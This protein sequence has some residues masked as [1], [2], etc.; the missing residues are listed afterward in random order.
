[1]QWIES[2]LPEGELERTRSEIQSIEKVEDDEKV[3]ENM[4]KY[5]LEH[6]PDNIL[7][8]SADSGQLDG[9]NIGRLGIYRGVLAFVQ[10]DERVF[11]SWYTPDKQEALEDCG[12]KEAGRIP[13]KVPHAM[14][15]PDQRQ[16]LVQNLP[17]PDDEEQI[18]ADENEE[19]IKS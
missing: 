8:R 9:D 6:V 14:P 1:M 18:S 12:Y 3:K 19:G 2:H 4:E 15:E 16:W 5:S 13:I 11:V 17:E 7:E 10:P